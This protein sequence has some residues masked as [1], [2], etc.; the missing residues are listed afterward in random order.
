[1]QDAFNLGWKLAL[2]TAG[3]AAAGLLDSYQAER[4][5]I[6]ARVIAQTT[7]VTDLGTTDH[8]VARKLRNH[9]VH[10]ATGLAPI[11]HR[12]ADATEETD[13]AYPLSPIVAGA[14]A[15]PRPGD[16]APDV[17][18]LEPALHELLAHATG[19]TLLYVAG[20]RDAAAVGPIAT[21]D[22][23]P[24][25]EPLRHVL[26]ADGAPTDSSFD[27][28]IADPDRLVAAR[29]GLHDTGGLVVVRPDGYIGLRADLGDGETLA[30]YLDRILG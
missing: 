7:R 11:R 9:A 16:A 6:A 1:M 28:V 26:V 18:G 15:S 5:P 17:P 20:A 22:N 30:L 24:A 23:T 19:H 2:A 12:L 10:L 3:K 14:Q 8:A 27:A 21:I 29:Y 25:G 13:I 4:H